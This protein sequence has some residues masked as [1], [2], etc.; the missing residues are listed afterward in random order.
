MQGA[1]VDRFGVSMSYLLPLLCFVVI[2]LFGLNSRRHESKFH[3]GKAMV[4]L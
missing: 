1:M 4:D 3:A 2:G